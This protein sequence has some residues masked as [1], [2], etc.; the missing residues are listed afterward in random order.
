MAEEDKSLFTGVEDAYV[1][2]YENFK[3]FDLSEED[4]YEQI[5]VADSPEE[6]SS[7]IA[8]DMVRGMTDA[9]NLPE[10]TLQSLKNGTSPFYKY[11]REK[12]AERDPSGNI[13]EEQS[14]SS[15]GFQDDENII[16]FFSILLNTTYM[17]SRHT[18][19][20]HFGVLI[21]ENV[22]LRFLRVCSSEQCVNQLVTLWV[23][24]VFGVGSSS[25]NRS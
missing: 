21:D 4:L 8:E 22:W 11:L 1:N 2:A 23:A 20:E 12:T 14:L 19:H 10:V 25:P 6:A 24:N 16:N 13:I 7:N 3:P 15:K 18:L 5:R 9:Y 17:L